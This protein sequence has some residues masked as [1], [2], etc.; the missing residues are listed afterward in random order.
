MKNVNWGK[1]YNEFKNEKLNPV[2]LE[3]KIKKLILDD[4]VTKKSGVYPYILTRE[5]KYLSIR[6]FSDQMKSEAFERQDGVCPLC[7]KEN[8]EKHKWDFE[9]MEA[10][11]IIPWHKGGK[12]IAENCQVLCVEH[13][14]I[15]S[16]K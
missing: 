13:N 11:H 15:K 1:L 2:K 10:D 8:K 7:K 3:G 9:E 14:R 6:S 16:G 12:T 5:E 4:D